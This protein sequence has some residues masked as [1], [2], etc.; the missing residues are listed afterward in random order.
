MTYP[1]LEPAT[2]YDQ[3]AETP[4]FYIEGGIRLYQADALEC[5]S[6]LKAETFDMI[7]ADPPY[8]LSGN[9]ITCQNGQMVSVN[10]GKWDT[11]RTAKQIHEFNHAWLAECRRVLTP[12]GTI[13]VSGT[14]HNIFSV[15]FAMQELG[16]KIL[17]DIAWFKINP[18]P[19]LACRYFTH[20]TET[21][22]WAK[23][24]EKARHYFN[25]AEMKR[26]NHG[27]QMM[28]LWQI[29]PPSK[30]EKRFGKHPTQKPEALLDRIIRASTEPGQLILDPFCGSGTTGVV[31]ARL[32]RRFVGIDLDEGYLALAQKRIQAAID[33]FQPAIEFEA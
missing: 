6:K 4:A 2:E 21:I 24:D 28:S 31:A 23:K 12:N 27:K 26:D 32:G 19:N 8:F 11:A 7:F 25:Y 30:Q 22:V 13:W 33:D 15:G 9:G 17:N 29:L 3:V 14:S 5:L 16:Y 1:S 20:S 18:P 10:K